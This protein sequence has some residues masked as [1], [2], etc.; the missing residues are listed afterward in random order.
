MS[1]VLAEDKVWSGV[2]GDLCKYISDEIS[3]TNRRV[4]WT[5]HRRIGIDFDI[6][7][8]IFQ[9][10]YRTR[11]IF[12]L[13]QNAADAISEDES[14]TKLG[15]RVKLVLTRGGLYC[16]NEGAPFTC[17]G[18][19]A[20]AY[21]VATA[22]FAQQIGRYGQGFKSVLAVTSEPWVFSHS[23]SFRYS[24]ELA[25]EFLLKSPSDIEVASGMTLIT[26]NELTSSGKPKLSILSIPV[27]VDPMVSFE[28]NPILKDLSSWAK[29]IVYL[30]FTDTPSFTDTPF[31]KNDDR[32]DEL[33]KSLDTF[34]PEFLVF[35]RH[36]KSL[37][38]EVHDDLVTN[39]TISCSSS[40]VVQG[41]KNKN[42]K[43]TRVQINGVGSEPRDWLLIENIVTP[44]ERLALTGPQKNRRRDDKGMQLPLPISWAVPLSP[45]ALSR[46]KFWFFLPTHDETTL[47]GIVNA[48]WDTNNERTTVLANSKYNEWLVQ[49][50][51][52]LIV[53][54]VPLL[55]DQFPNDIGHYL[56]FFPARGQEETSKPAEW[57]VEEVKKNVLINDSI[58]D[59]DRVLR[60]PSELSRP[61]DVVSAQVLEMWAKFQ[62][63]KRD[64]P[65]WTTAETANRTSRVRSYLEAAEHPGGVSPIEL[66]AWLEILVEDASVESSVAA[67]R[68]AIE[69]SKINFEFGEKV[70]SAK[71]VRCVDGKFT[72]PLPGQV[73]IGGPIAN[74]G[75]VKLIDPQVLEDEEVYRYL[76][77]ECRITEANDSAELDFILSL[78]GD[79]PTDDN[80]HSF[81][82]A[83]GSSTTDEI[84]GALS[85]HLTDDRLKDLK[86]RMIDGSWAS[87]D[88]CL[89]PGEIVVGGE[90]DDGFIVDSLFHHG[91]L[92][93]LTE[94]GATSIP[95]KNEGVVFPCG[96]VFEAE[97]RGMLV[98]N[99]MPK[100]QIDK[101]WSGRPRFP[102]H[103]PLFEKLGPQAK[104]RFTKSLLMSNREDLRWD[105]GVPNFKLES[106]VFWFVKKF[107][108]AITSIGPCKFEESLSPALSHLSRIGPVVEI[109][110]ELISGLGVKSTLGELP[111][112]ELL[113]VLERLGSEFDYVLIGECLS[114]IS[115]VIP[116]P[117][118]IPCR[119]GNATNHCKTDSVLVVATRELFERLAADGQPVILAL[120]EDAASSICKNWG[121]LGDGDLEQ[122]FEPTQPTEE[123]FLSDKYFLLGEINPH[124]I[125]NIKVVVC[126]SLMWVINGPLGM[127]RAGVRDGFDAALKTL[128]AVIEGDEFDRDL[129]VAASRRLDLHLTE[130]DIAKVMQDKESSELQDF[131]S[132]VRDAP[133]DIERVKRLFEISD[134]KVLLP[135]LILDEI[136]I[137]ASD[138]LILAEMVLAVHGPQLLSL[139]EA[140][141]ALLRMDLRPPAEWAGGRSAIEFV[142][143]LGFDRSFA[144]FKNDDPSSHIDV[145][146]F[147]RL[148][149]L[150]EYQEELKSE[151]KD[152]MS[153]RPKGDRWRSLLYLPTG[154]GKTRVTVQAVLELLHEGRFGNKPVVW[155]AQTYE[156]VDQAVQA[157][158]EVWSAMETTDTLSIDKFWSSNEIEQA[159]IPG[160]YA[161]QIVI[162]ID[163]KLD[164][165][166]NKTEYQWLQDAAIVIIDEAHR[167]LSPTYTRILQ[168]FKTGVRGLPKGDS[169]PLLGLS[170]TPAKPGLDR[171]FGPKM[172][173]IKS[174]NAPTSGMS[175]VDFL[176]SIGVLA[177]AD[178]QVIDGVTFDEDETFGTPQIWLPTPIEDK[179]AENRERN[180]RI[181]ESIM[182]LDSSWPVLV[183]AVSVSHA[184]FLAALLAKN[185]ITSASISAN[186]SKGVRRFQIKNFK[187]GKIRV[188]TNYGVLTTGFDA[189]KTRAIYIT[190]PCFSD[191]LYLQ[192]IGRGLRGPLNGG[193]DECLIVDVA[194]NFKNMKIDLVYKKMGEWWSNKTD[195]NEVNESTTHEGTWID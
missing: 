123:E 191:S 111:E 102:T 81:W 35:T 28:N 94:L 20:L 122:H 47:R 79:Q 50:F 30:P 44:P 66:C 89:L 75:D 194:D 36:V 137:D 48:P 188:L 59:L 25:K 90:S 27:P 45:G 133:N 143:E 51:G 61:P 118:L 168:W 3:P 178:H 187:D 11:Q 176:R 5:D 184:Q 192:M 63:P 149:R 144:G 125:A 38:F 193:T 62:G 185:G 155:V 147:I 23:G 54:S 100:R 43:A 140:K 49:K 110:S 183:F 160:E 26:E 58:P 65:H 74:N 170:A 130:D 95:I 1:V 165:A 69:V 115:Y 177:R 186:T 73:F 86:V 39:Y 148:P 8:L 13:I 21:P 52:E 68:V 53:E 195:G 166:R 127:T 33:K 114:A 180:K 12:E 105:S 22:K 76:V 173:R 117:D 167:A 146:G 15:G 136:G 161:G 107:G 17:E 156:L 153:E 85:R 41:M 77:D 190:R 18:V 98:E 150:H 142:R 55:I 116:R 121:L 87:I 71:I 34:P 108:L 124:A 92:D 42:L 106:P 83:C 175:D 9:G 64:F 126:S 6:V 80:W 134:L 88:S 139:K 19:T 32:F 159:N 141:T 174:R 163:A 104:A 152:L 171:R 158:R 128:Y 16:A 99:K 120:S 182:N 189:P 181:I 131:K 10:D 2:G 109:E 57:L 37:E 172:I 101:I 162:T 29:T 112:S 138:H 119:I 97:I 4:Y 145:A 93:T 46:G 154:A 157:F 113:K 72:A 169:R 56:D 129:L 96:D 60:K 31:F 179:L 82:T 67:I 24:F 70:K 164:N 84:I 132:L 7:E 135:R 151:L 91:V 103:L 78:F 40:D 14:T